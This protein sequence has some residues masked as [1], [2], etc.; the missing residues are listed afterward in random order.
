MEASARGRR[1]T[2]V[3]TGLGGGLFYLDLYIVTVALPTIQDELRLTGAQLAWTLNAVFLTAAA[4]MVTGGR[5]C[6]VVGRRRVFLAGVTL[7]LAAS[8]AAGLAQDGWWLVAARA[9]QGVGAALFFPA[10]TPIIVDAFAERE[11]ARAIGIWV[12]ALGVGMALGP[13][14]G[15]VLTQAL[16]WRSVF[17]V[18]VPF[19]L[20]AL[21][22]AVRG[23]RE[24]RADT[25]DDVVD[26]PGALA[27]T[28]G[29]LALVIALQQSQTEGWG[30]AEVLALLGAAAVALAL[31]AVVEQRARHPL[32]EFDLFRRRAYLGAVTI[33]FLSFFALSALIFFGTLYLQEVL[34]QSPS[35]AGL[36]FLPLTLMYVGA[37][38]VVGRLS[39]KVGA[40]GPLLSATVAL[41]VALLLFSRAGPATTVA[42]LVPMFLLAGY[43]LGTTYTL[44]TSTAMA[45]VELAKSG[46]ASGILSMARMAGAVFGVA[47]THP[48]FEAIDERRLH[49]LLDALGHETAAVREASRLAFASAF[50]G[51][52]LLCAAVAAAAVV[53][54]LALAPRDEAAQARP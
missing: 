26:V 15:G 52:M 24:S 29:L 50:E 20:V 47:V 21:A 34:R 36:M 1:M 12:G 6:D 13:L 19:G 16:G 7:F 9:A 48:L 3:A 30:S 51:S 5:L 54:A 32:V 49:H 14:V 46:T 53:A 11:R 18:N 31:F 27:V 41:T 38:P 23:V 4:G 17:Y 40:R 22:A 45:A 35:A 44:T 2:L 43:G 8:A 25:G 28:V 42:A 37:G 33:S 10:C 39:A